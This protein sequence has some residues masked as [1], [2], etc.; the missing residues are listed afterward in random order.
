[1]PGRGARGTPERVVEKRIEGKAG[2]RPRKKSAWDIEKRA[3]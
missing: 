2:V 3:H 1:M